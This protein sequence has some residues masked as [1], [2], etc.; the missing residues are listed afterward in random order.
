MAQQSFSIQYFLA[1]ICFNL[2]LPCH[3]WVVFHLLRVIIAMLFLSFE[4]Q[5][6]YLRSSNTSIQEE[7]SGFGC[8]K[9][10]TNG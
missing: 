3:E 9:F 7:K 5:S 4:F 1:L 8:T 2:C 10:E 6:T